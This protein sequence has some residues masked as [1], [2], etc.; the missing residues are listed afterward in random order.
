MLACPRHDAPIVLH[1]HS[2]NILL[3]EC[4]ATDA[5]CV[6]I[7]RTGGLGGPSLAN[8]CYRSHS[9]AQSVR[10]VAWTIKK[11]GD[12][13]EPQNDRSGSTDGSI[14][15]VFGEM[16]RRYHLTWR[17]HK[18]QGSD[19]HLFGGEGYRMLKSWELDRPLDIASLDLERFVKSWLADFDAA[20]GKHE[21][22]LRTLIETLAGTI[23]ETEVSRPKSPTD[24]A[25]AERTQQPTRRLLPPGKKPSNTHGE[26]G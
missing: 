4:D 17:F 22:T 16:C 18:P 15:L 14:A 8:G 23:G 2:V 7:T 21:E 5:S 10:S 13:H 24:A 9:A 3:G 12:C 11:V 6:P 19:V 26:A 20:A 25:T 1:P